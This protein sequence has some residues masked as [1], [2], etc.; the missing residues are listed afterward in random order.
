[1]SVGP[2]R[3]LRL[4]ARS[5]IW[6]KYL[7]RNSSIPG[8]NHFSWLYM[9]I[10]IFSV[11]P[12]RSSD[13]SQPQP[14]IVLLDLRRKKTYYFNK[15]H[16]VLQSDLLTR[17]V[18]VYTEPKVLALLRSSLAQWFGRW[19]SQRF[20]TFRN[21]LTVPGSTNVTA[22]VNTLPQ[23]PVNIVWDLQDRGWD[24]WESS[25]PLFEEVTEPES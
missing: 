25:L 9:T 3:V 14:R 24:G 20:S 8:N 1:M 6:W 18:L 17:L 10:F 5:L 12:P 7:T 22:R 16:S 21:T 23:P 4:D 13:Q 15:C 2:S 19:T 11:I